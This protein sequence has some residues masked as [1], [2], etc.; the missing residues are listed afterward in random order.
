MIAVRSSPP[1]CQPCSAPRGTWNSAP[2]VTGYLA[3]PSRSSPPRTIAMCSH[4]RGEPSPAALQRPD[5]CRSERLAPSPPP[6]SAAL[7]DRRRGNAT[8]AAFVPLPQSSFGAAAR[9]ATSSVACRSLGAPFCSD[10]SDGLGER[11]APAQHDDENA[12]LAA[13]SRER[14]AGAGRAKGA[15]GRRAR[16]PSLPWLDRPRRGATLPSRTTAR[17]SSLRA[18]GEDEG[19]LVGE[20]LEPDRTLRRAHPPGGVGEGGVR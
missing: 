10:A 16:A 6:S 20:R 4:S 7:P 9:S 8:R 2:G 15:P 1:P 19:A 18:R 3:L 14:V 5:T 13:S 12:R 17:D 11:P